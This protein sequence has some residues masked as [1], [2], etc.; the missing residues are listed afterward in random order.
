MQNT[1]CHDVIGS[2]QLP[3]PVVSP[4]APSL[5]EFL[6]PGRSPTISKWKSSSFS[7][8]KETSSIQVCFQLSCV[9]DP[10][11]K[12]WTL[13]ERAELLGM[14]KVCFLSTLFHHLSSKIFG[15]LGALCC[16]GSDIWPG[17]PETAWSEPGVRVGPQI[18]YWKR[19]DITAELLALKGCRRMKDN[20]EYLLPRSVFYC[21]AVSL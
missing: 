13:L 14:Q 3:Y 6:F 10:I 18:P 8:G 5:L 12:L 9:K 21:I 16:V 20:S 19:V 15:C 4:Y 7:P 11:G 1:D 17:L 2:A